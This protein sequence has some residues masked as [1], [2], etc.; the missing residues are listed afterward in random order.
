MLHHVANVEE[1]GVR[2]CEVVR[3]TDGE[4]C[5]LDWHLE[6]TER[7]HF[8]AISEVEI[9]EGCFAEICRG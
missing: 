3:A 5:V 1:G 9:I 4:G 8:A 6:T 2:T 7:D